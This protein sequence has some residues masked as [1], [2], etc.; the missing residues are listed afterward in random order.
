MRVERIGD[1]AEFVERTQLFRSQEPYLTNVIGTTAVSVA[2]GLRTYEKMLW[3]VVVD[4]HDVVRGMMMRTTPH[5]LVLSPMPTDALDAVVTAVL[6]DDPGIPGVSGSKELVTAFLSKFIDASGRPVTP[7][8]ERHLLIYV[9]GSL[10]PPTRAAGSARVCDL[11]EFDALLTWYSAFAM[12]TDIERY[13]L[14]EILRTSLAQSRVFVWMDEGRPVCAAA[15]APIV[16][17]P[18]GSIARIGPVYTPPAERQKGYASQLT[19][20][21]SSRLL[22]RG[23][24]V[25]L[26]TNAQNP[27]S[28][29]VYVRLG[30]QRLDDIVEYVLDGLGQDSGAWAS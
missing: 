24:G 5:K 30:Y 26:F 14:E 25:M 17:T 11:S 3:W 18:S 23:L 13:G 6:D 20:D 28:N 27:T 15:H 10:L 29:G 9:L 2:S 1:A 12:E 21:V 8:L 7:I 4:E 19:W 22:D 16:T